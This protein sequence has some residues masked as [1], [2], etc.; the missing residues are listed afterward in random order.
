MVERG[1]RHESGGFSDSEA[2]RRNPGVAN[3]QGASL[4]R[5]GER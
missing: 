5:Q 2:N 3:T 4:A 1:V